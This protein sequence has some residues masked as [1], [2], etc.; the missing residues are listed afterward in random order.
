MVGP[1]V[2]FIQAGFDGP[3]KIGYTA[4][5][6]EERMAALQVSHWEQLRLV[7]VI[8]GDRSLEAGFHA[9]LRPHRIRGEWFLPTP[10]VLAVV[11]TARETQAE[12]L[13]TR[14]ELAEIDFAAARRRVGG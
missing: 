3:V 7:A 4:R 9:A 14:A 11:R 1:S 6:P 12:E 8:P 5:E 10:T 2:Y 13:V